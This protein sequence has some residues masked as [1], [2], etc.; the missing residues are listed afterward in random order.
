MAVSS[1]TMKQDLL[2]EC[3]A[4][5]STQKISAIEF[6]YT[7]PRTT[8]IHIGSVGKN[9]DVSFGMRSCSREVLNFVARITQ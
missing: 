7:H 3:F 2:G 8:T 5:L 6:S 1:I 4:C 9:Q